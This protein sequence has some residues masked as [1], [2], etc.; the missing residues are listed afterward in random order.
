M[1]ITHIE[2]IN[3]VL[4][5]DELCMYVITLRGGK[6]K[7]KKTITCSLCQ[8]LVRAYE[9]PT[10]IASSSPKAHQALYTRILSRQYVIVPEIICSARRPF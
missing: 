4:M 5:T 2:I 8:L 10:A 3:F 6:L 7:K 9:P 1:G